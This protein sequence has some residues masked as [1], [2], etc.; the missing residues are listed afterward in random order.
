MKMAYDPTSTKYLIKAR[1]TAD[2]VVEVPDVIG[3]IFGQ[4]EGI[5]G[6]KLNIRD[7]YKSGRIGRIEVQLESK[8]GKTEG[9]ILIPSGLEA[10]ETAIIAATLESVD[11]IGP[12]KARVVVESIEDVRTE[13]RKKIASRAKELYKQIVK[14]TSAQAEDIIKEVKK[15]L[16]EEEVILYGEDRLPA[17]PDVPTSEDV[18]VVEGRADVLNLLRHGIRNAIAVEGTNVPKTIVELSKRKTVT[19]FVDGDRGGELLLKELLQVADVDYV[20][21]APE[22]M[23]VESLTY[24]QIQKA[25]RDKVPA[26]Q[27]REQ[28]FGK[29]KEVKH[30]AAKKGAVLLGEDGKEIASVPVSDLHQALSSAKGIREIVL[31]GVLTQ[32]IVDLAHQKGVKKIRAAKMES[33]VKLP[34][35]LEIEIAEAK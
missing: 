5:L 34:A 9:K 11:R 1:F 19:V 18:I 27:V 15:S 7:L 26:E 32:R 23:E 8:K 20:A 35:G 29:K 2:G 10:I 31:D 30:R 24:K 22:N 28:L 3:A 13:K 21:R 14:S 12:C 17:G 25:L 6:P 4:A 16:E 33:V